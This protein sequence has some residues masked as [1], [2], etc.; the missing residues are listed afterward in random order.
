MR[1]G[2]ARRGAIVPGM[3][4][5][6]TFG[7]RFKRPSPV[8][9]ATLIF[10]LVVWIASAIAI[11]VSP[12]GKA[13][14]D[15]LAFDPLLVLQGQ[16]L[17]A[18]VTGAMLH[19]LAD[20]DHLLFNGLAFYFFATDLEELWGRGRFLAFMF[21]C[22]IGGHVFVLLAALLG[23]GSAP[24]V[25]FSGVVLGVITAFGL[26]YPEREI[27]FFFFRLKAIY[28]VYL[29]LAMQ[30]L[31]ALSFSRVSAAAHLGGMAAGAI[32]AATRSGPLRRAWLRRKLSRLEEQA[33][34]MRRDDEPPLSRRRSGG[35]E[36]RVI[37]GGASRPK[38]R[39]DLN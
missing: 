7:F 29:T 8:V 3:Q 33:A 34:A 16:H 35:P 22:A 10:L 24:V 27:F 9:G 17:W 26:T 39:R 11:R 28:L 18:F 19:S 14:Y 38:D 15:A 32:F 6:A 36:L 5:D 4:Q 25:G 2:A 12:A 20:T 23:L 37:R 31:T 30:L 21:L 13:L 1:V